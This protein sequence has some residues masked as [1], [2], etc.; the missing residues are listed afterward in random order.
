MIIED[1]AVSPTGLE[2][3]DWE[4]ISV[5]KL[6][7]MLCSPPAQHSTTCKSKKHK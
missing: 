6:E 3:A 5:V 2:W 4:E 7:L 1:C